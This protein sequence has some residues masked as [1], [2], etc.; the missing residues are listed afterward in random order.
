VST[1]QVTRCMSDFR[2]TAKPPFPSSPPLPP[3]R[4]SMDRKG[5]WWGGC[6]D[7]GQKERRSERGR[8]CEGGR[9]EGG[10]LADTLWQGQRGAINESWA[11]L[12]S[13]GGPHLCLPLRCFVLRLPAPA[14]RHDVTACM[15]GTGVPEEEGDEQGGTG[16]RGTAWVGERCRGKGEGRG[17]E[18]KGEGARQRG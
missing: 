3:W 9:T 10:V 13:A 15:S 6:Q 1:L 16:M 18:G 7:K 14:P 5:A 17:G 12:H 11:Q 2:N 4:R 8:R